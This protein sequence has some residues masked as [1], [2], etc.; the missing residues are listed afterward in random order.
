MESIFYIHWILL[1]NYLPQNRVA[2][3][4]SSL[5][6]YRLHIWAELSWPSTYEILV[7]LFLDEALARMTEISE[8]AGMT[9]VSPQIVSYL[10][11]DG[12]LYILVARFQD[13]SRNDE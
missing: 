3:N 9:G 7:W 5:I 4:I 1:W 12:P 11:E 2:L 13:T 10:L 6:W 8:I